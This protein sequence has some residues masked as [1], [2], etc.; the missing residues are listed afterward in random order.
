LLFLVLLVAAA[1]PWVGVMYWLIFRC[2]EVPDAQTRPLPV[3]AY[4]EP[5]QT[6]LLTQAWAF[7]RDKHKSTR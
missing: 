2:P 3:M 1:A 6:P 4:E 5:Q 7:L